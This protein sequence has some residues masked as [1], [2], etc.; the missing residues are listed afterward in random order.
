M[1]H[2]ER[3]NIT[4]PQPCQVKKKLCD[5]RQSVI[6]TR[7]YVAHNAIAVMLGVMLRLQRLYQ[8]FSSQAIDIGFDHNKTNKRI[9]FYETA[10]SLSFSV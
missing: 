3:F 4:H 7:K 9:I 8:F 10:L 6:E 1:L 5:Y 2:S